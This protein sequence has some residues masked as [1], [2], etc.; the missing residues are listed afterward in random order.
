[1]P[2]DLERIITTAVVISGPWVVGAAS[3]RCAVAEVT[4]AAGFPNWSA[5]VAARSGREAGGVRY[6]ERG[7]WTAQGC[8]DEEGVV[9]VDAAAIR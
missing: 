3:G 6:L 4:E 2:G 5:C 9:W 7:R 1:M 8:A